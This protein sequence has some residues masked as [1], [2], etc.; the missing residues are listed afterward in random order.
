[1]AGPSDPRRPLVY[2]VMRMKRARRSAASEHVGELVRQLRGRAGL[3][4]VALAE[5]AGLDVSTLDRVE[6]G[7]ANPTLFI[8]LRIASGLDV[9]P[10]TLVTGLTAADLPDEI[11]PYSEE[12]FR[13]ALRARPDGEQPSGQ[14]ARTGTSP[15]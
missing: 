6:G 5:R 9:P 4:R 1:M 10:E 12:D 13:R 7:Q 2:I 8:L 11:R 14:S 15:R 3:S